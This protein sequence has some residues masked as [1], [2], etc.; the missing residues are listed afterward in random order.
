MTQPGYTHDS[1]HRQVPPPDGD[2]PGASRSSRAARLAW[3]LVPIL[4]LG[5][6]TFVP[7]L[8]V[9][10][11][12][13]GKRDWL[14]FLGYLLTA[15]LELV[16]GGTVGH[17]GPHNQW[18]QSAGVIIIFLT[19][20]GAVHTYTVMGPQPSGFG[21]AGGLDHEPDTAEQAL[22]RMEHQRQAREIAA[23]NPALCRELGIG[24]PDRPR[25]YNDG[26]LIDINHVPRWVLTRGL[27]FTEEE[28]DR[29]L[30]ARAQ[31][32][33][34]SSTAEVTTFAPFAPG[35]LEPIQDLIIFG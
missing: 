23:T 9:A 6:L 33:R 19:I 21:P 17:Y 24:R 30:E 20:A 29:V 34:F 4:S 5:V 18:K 26:G 12:R 11:R 35:R 31:V 14:H 7:F 22:A 28:A 16:A 13:R 2:Q 1:R 25:S 32:G 3:T 10:L 15:V 27:G 8:V